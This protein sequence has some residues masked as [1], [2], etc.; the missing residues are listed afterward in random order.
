M[1]ATIVLTA[2]LV[3]SLHLTG[4]ALL[5]AFAIGFFPLGMVVSSI[6]RRILPPR[7]QL[8]RD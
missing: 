3:F 2:M 5:L 7:L 1:I 8:G 6:G 4:V